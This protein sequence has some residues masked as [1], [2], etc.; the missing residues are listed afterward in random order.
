MVRKA[1]TTCVCGTLLS[2]EVPKYTG[3]V[4]VWHG[5]PPIYRSLSI[6]GEELACR[7]RAEQLDT[8]AD[9]I[10]E[11]VAELHAPQA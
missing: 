1:L 11:W 6:T 7:E 4:E 10:T 8:I 5:L 2:Y 3:T 9:R